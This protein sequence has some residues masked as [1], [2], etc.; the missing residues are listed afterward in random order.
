MRE[1]ITADLQK[2]GLILSLEGLA[3]L[4]YLLAIPSDGSGGVFLGFSTNRLILISVVLIFNLLVVAATLT[5]RREPQRMQA[6]VESI[7]QMLP[8]ER[9]RT[10]LLSLLSTGL[11][12]GT[13]LLLF[14]GSTTDQF[15][16]GILSRLA[17][18]LLLG[19][20]S[21]AQLIYYFLGWLSTD[22]RMV[23]RRS[24]L[25]ASFL[26]L[27]QWAFIAELH[28]RYSIT[29]V[30]ALLL[31]ISLVSYL[32][33]AQSASISPE[34]R[35]G[36]LLGVG[37]VVILVA[38]QMLLIPKSHWRFREEIM[39]FSP[40]F[41]LLL[42]FIGRYLARETFSIPRNN[43]LSRALLIGFIAIFILLGLAFYDGAIQHS[44]T[45]N[46]D[47]TGDQ[48]SFMGFTEEVY[49]SGFSNTGV[50]SQMP[51]YPFL[52]ALF[53]DPDNNLEEFFLSGKEIN[54]ILSL[55]LLVLLFA[56]FQFFLPLHQAA[57]LVLVVAFASFIFRS[58]YF[59]T[60]ILYYFLSFLA[61]LL[62]AVMLIKPTLKLGIATGLVL[63]FT[64]LTK[65]SIIPGA[66]LFLLV[67]AIKEGIRFFERR[68]DDS[69]HPQNWNWRRSNMLSLLF[70]ILFFLG[71]IFPYIRE[72]KK[73]YGQYFYNLAY[74]VM[75]YD[76]WEDAE[77]VRD[78]YGWQNIPEDDLPGF[79]NYFANHS[80]EQITER[81][82]YGLSRQGENI[83]Y[84]FSFF[85]F[86]IFF[87]IYMF[88]VGFL[89]W[90]QS[91]ALIKR[92]IFLTAFVVLFHAGYFILF[93]W[94]SPIVGLSRFIYGLFIPFLFSIFVAVKALSND[95]NLPGTRLFDLAVS[96]MLIVDVN[97]VLSTGL[98]LGTFGS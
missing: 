94:Y 15:Y 82:R 7:E 35:K 86:P 36:W 87:L 93:V 37:F 22:H 60:E 67:F 1:K 61:F 65:A 68:K 89:R 3:S 24:L 41:I 98:F 13:L 21:S 43:W 90:R 54:I 50:R 47:Y 62:M 56:I 49:Q 48:R 46:D 79:G 20:L 59:T 73:E 45:I 33:S 6:I 14:W 76:S 9:I 83:R 18:L 34:E 31:I 81:V 75:W 12:F 95:S 78:Q 64:H 85:H 23:W 30:L 32:L 10:L 53:F 27:I 29:L 55:L 19:T 88:L 26:T 80:L 63:G 52:Q 25:V 77:A 72:S 96:V 4:L 51:L 57:N 74:V 39:R 44:I 11:I 16:Q 70:A 97:Y 8:H 5:I 84:Q 28:H 42:L 71:V 38:A 17:P 69:A 40:V 58:A 66:L 2:L 92:N 91:L